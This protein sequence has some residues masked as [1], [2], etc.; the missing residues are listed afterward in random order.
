MRVGTDFDHFMPH[1]SIE[2][3]MLNEIERS[4]VVSAYYERSS[5]LMGL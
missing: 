1:G 5:H 4:R 2:K 3:Q